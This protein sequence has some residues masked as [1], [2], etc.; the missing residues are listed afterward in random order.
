MILYRGRRKWE[1]HF[2]ISILK[3]A[4][5]TLR[6]HL[7]S[8]R[9]A[10]SEKRHAREKKQR[11]FRLRSCYQCIMVYRALCSHLWFPVFFVVFCWLPGMNKMT[12]GRAISANAPVITFGKRYGYLFIDIWPP[13][14]GSSWGDHTQKRWTNQR[15]TYLP[16]SNLISWHCNADRWDTEPLGAYVY[17]CGVALRSEGVFRD[18]RAQNH[19]TFIGSPPT[20]CQ[21]Y[22][23][24]FVTFFRLKFA[25]FVGWIFSCSSSNICLLNSAMF[26]RHTGCAWRKTLQRGE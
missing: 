12:S 11:Q 15:T 8:L 16:T 5:Q 17:R 26:S 14:D 24:V 9:L 23:K 1:P 4:M 20:R 6:C 2:F 18:R 21:S 13:M 10:G 22:I 19:Q 7:L 3:T 25:T